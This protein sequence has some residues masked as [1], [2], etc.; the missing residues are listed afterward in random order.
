MIK[1][2][3]EKISAYTEDAKLFTVE[4]FDD[5]GASIDIDALQ[6]AKSWPETSAAIQK[7]LD[8]MNLTGD[9]Q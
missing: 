6:S 7:A 3:P 9:T 5:A 2:Y 1:I 4:A 8:M